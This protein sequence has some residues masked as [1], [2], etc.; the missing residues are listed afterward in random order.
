MVEFIDH[1]LN[2]IRWQVSADPD[3]LSP[4]DFNSQYVIGGS[5]KNVSVWK[6]QDDPANY[7]RMP[8]V[9]VAS[10]STESPVVQVMLVGKTAFVA[11]RSGIVVLF[12]LDD[13]GDKPRK[14]LIPISKTPLMHNGKQCNG[15]L[16]SPQLN[17]VITCG[18]D[19]SIS[20]CDIEKNRKT[21]VK[22]HHI[23]DSSIKCIDSIT[24]N[25]IVCGT[26]QG[27]LIH[28]D[29]RTSRPIEVYECKG[30]SALT[31]VQRNPNVNHLVVGGND[32]GFIN[33]YDLRHQQF[34]VAKIPT[35]DAAITGLK[36]QPRVSDS[37]Y[38]SS[39]DHVLMKLNM[40]ADFTS[41]Q[42]PKADIL[43]AGDDSVSITCFDVNQQG[44]LIYATD[45]EVLYYHIP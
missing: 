6:F 43:V 33:L 13:A 1:N 11:L 27:S 40:P 5:H 17:S 9:E 38:S 7:Q 23:S 31:C 30:H 20:H 25:Q 26:Q 22:T 41:I 44:N 34:A 19:G 10:E 12:E 15:L 39:C 4:F 14:E 24:P 36:Y 28:H 42:K 32:E 8:I 45:V 35:H 16:F 3:N 29:L 18:A 37:F 21:A 2:S